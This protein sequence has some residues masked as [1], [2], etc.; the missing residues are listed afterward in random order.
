M[1]LTGSPALPII[2]R[3]TISLTIRAA[4]RSASIMLRGSATPWPAIS[5]AVPWSTDVRITGRPTV[6]F[7]PASMPSTLTGPWPWSWYMATIRS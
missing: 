2:A 4:C 3:E 6:M 5:N 1:W 7:T